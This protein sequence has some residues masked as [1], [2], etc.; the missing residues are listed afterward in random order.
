METYKLRYRFEPG[1]GV[2]LWSEN[3]LARDRFGYPVELD[4]LELESSMKRQTEALIV[5]F[6]TSIDWSYPPAPS[7]WSDVERKR[8]QADAAG[9]LRSLQK[10]LGVGFE[11][12]DCTR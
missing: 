5:R 8:F 10:C 3:D 4:S 12:R 2:C 6:D 7:P 1:S 11:I 9:L